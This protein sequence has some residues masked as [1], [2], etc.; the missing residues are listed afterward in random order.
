MLKKKAEADLVTAEEEAKLIIAKA[1][2]TQKFFDDNSLLVLAV[3]ALLTIIGL[4]M[5]V[6]QVWTW[7]KQI[8]NN[9][10]SLPEVLRDDIDKVL[11]KVPLLTTKEEVEGY[12]KETTKSFNRVEDAL[13]KFAGIIDETISELEKKAD[14]NYNEG[15]RLLREQLELKEEKLNEKSS[16]KIKKKYIL[17]VLEIKKRI[18][19]AKNNQSDE[20]GDSFDIIIDKVDRFLKNE[21]VKVLSFE[22]GN[23]LEKM[24]PFEFEKVESVQTN[25]DSLDQTICETVEIGYYLEAPNDKK[26]V[27]IPAKVS[28]YVPIQE[29]ESVE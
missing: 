7:R 5:Y 26:A 13:P 21:G 18:L 28:I 1:K 23:A 2:K 14:K 9:S 16:L 24:L 19:F 20:L 12:G 3:F 25:S 15:L 10:I 27:I 11:K 8:D 4:L 17:E 29:S 22:K 6:F